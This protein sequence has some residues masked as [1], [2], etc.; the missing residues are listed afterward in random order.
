MNWKKYKDLP[1][2]KKKDESY[3][4]IGLDVGNDSSAI[5]FYNLADGAAETID[6]SGGYGKP[7]IP[8]V[9]QYISETKEWV[10]GEYAV[11][12][13]GVGTVFSSLLEKMGRFDHLDVGGRSVS[14][15]GVFALFI[16]ELLSNVKNINP[17]AE[18]VGI[19]ASVPAYFTEQAREEFTR[20]FKLA[21]YEKELISLVPDR[22][23][24]LTHFYCTDDPR[25]ASDKTNCAL[26]IDLGSRELRGGLYN[27]EKKDGAIT[28]VSLSSVFDDKISMAAL[29]ADVEKLFTSFLPKPE[30]PV[31]TGNAPAEMREHLSAFTHQHKD[32]LF[33]KNIRTKPLKLYYN[34]VYPPF[35][36]TLT[37]DIVE[38]LIAPYA[39]RFNQFIR[40]V[41][42][43]NLNDEA[44]ASNRVDAVLCVGG[45]FEMLWAKE[46]VTSVFPKE[47]VKFYKNPKLVTAEGAALIA[48]RELEIAGVPLKLEDNHQLKNDIGLSD[49]EN[50]LTL[51][52]KNGFWW[53]NH[54]AKLV[55]VNSAV[56]GEIE[57]H[58]TG[59]TPE[60]EGK[61]LA[62]MN[63]KGLPARPKGVTRLEITLNFRSNTELTVLIRD[64]GFGDLFPKVDYER[65]FAVSL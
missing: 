55:L 17:K 65:E 23:C 7:S 37:N 21:G 11:L 62:K 35:Q 46:A 40:D 24:V 12:N 4:I 52:E 14:V 64:R 51:V 33:Q 59:L 39:K 38:K 28:A 9:M 44:I 6:L 31:A 36:H 19:A 47:R 10:F 54:P 27:A 49:G 50:F 13:R 42:E 45:G 58:L 57:L 15:A 60:G 1:A 43:K 2:A 5:A 61:S 29:N 34:F 30:G 63:L 41:L 53:Q 22:E 3:Y 56:S 48:A 8:T 26:L 25:G 16:K 20:V 18:I 32:I